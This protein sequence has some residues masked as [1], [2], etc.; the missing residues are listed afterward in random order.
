MDGR[1]LRLS[2]RLSV[3]LVDCPMPDPQSK[4]EGRSKLKVGTNE[5]HDTGDL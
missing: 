3:C 5:A 2:V 1:C 4:T